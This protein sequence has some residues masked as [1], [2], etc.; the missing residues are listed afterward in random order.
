L[1]VVASGLKSE[2]AVVLNMENGGFSTLE[3]L[4]D[5]MHASCLLP[6]IAGPVMNLDTR[7]IKDKGSAKTS[8]A[9][10]KKMVLGN[11][12]EGEHYEPLADALLF[13]PLPYRSPIERDGATHVV[14]IR[15]RPDGVDVTGKGGFFERLIFHRFFMRKNRLPNMYK[16]MTQ[17]LHKK[18]YGEDVLRLNE[19]AYSK[20]DYKDTSKPHLL[21]IAVPPGS[22]EVTRLEVG[23]EAIF[24]GLRR[25][26]ARA[27]DC[28]VEDPAERGRG[29][30]VAKEFF[31]DEIL[32][33]D[34]A[35]IDAVEESAFATYMREHN[36]S[37]K[38][39]DAV[40]NKKS[41]SPDQAKVSR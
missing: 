30:E 32:D 2:K 35:E 41:A 31:P 11:N 16:R 18:L 19:E 25:G 27:Y 39:W 40:E 21:A 7:A 34:P 9:S 14:V 26:F 1:N 12:L 20:R 4:T 13:E 23:R 6:G 24:E 38:A 37:P 8:N 3:E 17:Q 5:C 36:I 10:E 22:D 15:S 33:Y 28:L 29:A